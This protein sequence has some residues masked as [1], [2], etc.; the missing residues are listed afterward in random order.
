MSDQIL[1]LL[2][3][4]QAGVDVTLAP[5]EYTIGSGED[6]DLK[7]MDVSL[8]QGHLRLR[9]A[10]EEG[11]SKVELAGGAGTAYI[12]VQGDQTIEIEPGDDNWH[13]LEP[14]TRVTMGAIEFAVGPADA[15][16]H[17]LS[18]KPKGKRVKADT[19]SKDKKG[20]PQITGAAARR[21]LVVTYTVFFAVV[22]WFIFGA[23]DKEQAVSTVMTEE[24]VEQSVRDAVFQ[25]A[26][27]NNITVT[28]EVDGIFDIYGYVETAAERRAIMQDVRQLRVPVRERIYGRAAI[29]EESKSFLEAEGYSD[30]I[31]ADVTQD[32]E[33]VL[34]G[35]LLET[36]AVERLVTF[37]RTEIF[38][39]KSVRSDV[40]TIDYFL[41]SSRDLAKSSGIAETVIFQARDNVIEA[42]GVIF[43]ERVDAWVGFLQAYSRRFA[44]TVPLRSFVY[45][46]NR[47]GTVDGDAEGRLPVV[48]GGEG[49]G[50]SSVGVD[51]MKVAKGEVRASDLFA[52]REGESRTSKLQGIL[53]E[54]DEMAKK[55]AINQTVR[56]SIEDGEIIATGVVFP[57]NA[58]GWEAF[59]K[60]FIQR[61]GK[62]AALRSYVSFAKANTIDEARQIVAAEIGN[63]NKNAVLIGDGIAPRAGETI[64]SSDDLLGGKAGLAALF[65]D[66]KSQGALNDSLIAAKEMLRARG[67]HGQVMLSIIGDRIVARG[68]VTQEKIPAWLEFLEEFLIAQD[69]NVAIESF[70][71][72]AGAEKENETQQW[73]EVISGG[74]TNPVVF[75]NG[76]AP[77]GRNAISAE[78]IAQGN[79]DIGALFAGRDTGALGSIRQ[80]R[81]GRTAEKAGDESGNTLMASLVDSA[82]AARERAMD[83]TLLA[84]AQAEGYTTDADELRA[85]TDIILEK[86][87]EAEDRANSPIADVA[88]AWAENLRLKQNQAEA[89]DSEALISSFLQL[90]L[91]KRHAKIPCWDNSSI[92][93]DNLTTTLFWL[94]LLHMSREAMLAR[95]DPGDQVLLAE[96]A[97]SPRKLR[98]CVEGF[99]EIDS[100]FLLNASVYLQDAETNQRVADR[101][102]RA[103]P[104]AD[105]P[106]I[107]VDLTGPRTLT[108]ASGERLREG[109][110]GESDTKLLA[111]GELGALIGTS[112]GLSVQIYGNNLSWRID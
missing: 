101:I 95:L 75:S 100:A 104:K 12:A 81:R 99:S 71:Q 25:H 102:L 88:A 103:I 14:L 23:N 19:K 76:N 52:M 72:F 74:E 32:G 21:M 68:M 22:I 34:S 39:A 51:A 108:L 5:G 18:N 9:V 92:T 98:E 55:Y 106:L 67:L 26:F 85:T 44:E 94:D 53:D 64:V 77:D 50:R 45:L 61:Y 112:Q 56:F 73:L 57:Q 111:I 87:G 28:R 80:H 46:A 1:K 60:E 27:A 13:P 84:A 11:E 29:L 6:D 38:G 107:G 16:W 109:A 63:K 110:S 48:I 35:T 83:G 93:R 49:D 69:G 41:E 7:L 86:W 4:N 20:R 42:T 89:E 2:T 62:N 59:L 105:M 97:L 54:L 24:E 36:A 33:V 70:V 78:T 66:E 15:A 37:L 10:V 96:A 17:S 90:Y 79:V 47:D 30:V 58:E 65:A 43:Q 8:R 40:H 3:G 31:K 82:I 91:R